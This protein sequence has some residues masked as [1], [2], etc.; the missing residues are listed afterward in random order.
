MARYAVKGQPWRIPGAVNVEDCKTT[1]E[2]MQKSHL[3]FHVKKCPLVAKMPFNMDRTD[4]ILDD[5]NAGNCFSHEGNIYR[6]CPDAFGTFRTDVD[7]PL[8][9]VK[10]KYTV[11]DNV[12]AFK[13]FDSA[14]GKDEAIWQTAGY[15]GN[16]ERVFVSAKLPKTIKV[17]GDIIENYLVFANSHDGSSGVN[18]LFTPIRVVCQNTLNA[19]IKTAESFVRFRHTKSVHNNIDMAA[20]LLDIVKDQAVIVEDRFNRLSDTEINDIQA[21]EYIFKTYLGEAELIN[22]KAKKPQYLDEDEFIDKLFK[23]DYGSM[24]RAGISSRMA[25]ILNKTYDYY[26]NGIGQ[27]EI[28]NTAYGAY[29]A[30]TGYYANVDNTVGEDRMKKVL[31]GSAATTMANALDL[32]VKMI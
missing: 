12:D 2:V 17:N 27:Q 23:M 9:I 15:F 26:H 14:I 4:E 1:L 16:G 18:I 29:N 13:F 25:G 32:A 5:I 20:D 31:Y 8:G 24:E 10:S 22:T 30:I 28:V 11:V 21:K 3:D 7:I 19:A 6:D